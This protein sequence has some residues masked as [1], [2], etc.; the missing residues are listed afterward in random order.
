MTL[1]GTPLI[2]PEEQRRRQEAYE[3]AVASNRL[4]GYEPSTEFDA[5]AQRFI[6]GEFDLVEFKR[7]VD[8]LVKTY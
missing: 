5:I 2:S 3:F 1:D 7:L 4:S 8:E 6:Q